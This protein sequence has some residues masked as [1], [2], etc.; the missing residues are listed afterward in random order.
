MAYTWGSTALSVQS[1]SSDAAQL[2]LSEHPLIPDPAADHDSTPSSV[3]MGAGRLRRKVT[4]HGFASSSDYAAMKSDAHDL[5][6]RTLE[7][8]AGDTLSAVI[9]SLTGVRD[10]VRGSLVWYTAT[11]VE[12]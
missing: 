3:L 2:N 5:T 12:A 4:V 9:Q 8:D 11:F 6:S 10:V 7:L 1:F